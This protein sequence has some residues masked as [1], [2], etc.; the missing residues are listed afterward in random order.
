MELLTIL[1]ICCISL[2]LLFYGFLLFSADTSLKNHKKSS[3]QNRIQ[4]LKASVII[5]VRNEEKNIL[6][7]IESILKGNPDNKYYDIII[8][9]DHSTDNTKKLLNSIEVKNVR[10]YD[11]P[12]SISGKKNALE[13]G[14][15]R[16]SAEIIITTDGDCLLPQ[17]WIQNIISHYSNNKNLVMTTGLVLPSGPNTTIGRFQWLDFAATMALTHYGISSK[18]F[19]LANGAN[20]S[21]LKQSFLDT[22]GFQDNLHVASG[23]DV[24]LIKKLSRLP[25]KEI[26]FLP[27]P[28]AKVFTK[29]E[30]TWKSLIQQRKRWATKTKAYAN[31]HILSIQA[32]V[33]GLS[34]FLNIFILMAFIQPKYFLA[35]FLFLCIGKYS[36]DYFFLKKLSYYFQNKHVM[37][38]FLVSFIIYQFYILLMGIYALLPGHT[39]WKDRKVRQ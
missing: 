38:N 15:L 25:G 29:A 34:L 23:D 4:N 14:L 30:D 12:Q 1:L 36:I 28:E 37:K 6:P 33:F 16:T 8:I 21:Y 17:G 20:M 32:F 2:L 7:C 10:S 13:Y 39:H 5:A 18:K 22:G 9:N 26:A 24:F 19:Y 11:L 31:I 27:S 3:P 35:P